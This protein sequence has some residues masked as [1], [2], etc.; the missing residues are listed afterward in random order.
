M[1]KKTLSGKIDSLGND[2]QGFERK[3]KSSSSALKVFHNL[4]NLERTGTNI[5]DQE[6][7][8]NRLKATIHEASSAS[9]SQYTAGFFR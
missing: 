4:K 3:R 2:S 6:E 9:K 7:S 8:S 5:L 1:R